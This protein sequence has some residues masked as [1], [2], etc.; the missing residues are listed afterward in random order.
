MYKKLHSVLR[1]N[2]TFHIIILYIFFVFLILYLNKNLYFSFENIKHFSTYFRDDIVFVYNSLLYSQGLEI[3]HLDHPS[4]FTYFIFT[5][6]YK[7][8]SLLGFLDVNDLNGLINSESFENSLNRLFYISRLAIQIFS[9]IVIFLFYKIANKF[10]SN[11]IISF[12]G[13]LL[14]IF[15]VGFASGSNRIE[16]GLISVFF[17]LLTM[18]YLIKFYENTNKKGLIYFLLSCLFLF[19]SMMQKKII[20]FLYPFIFLSPIF[21]IKYSSLEYMKYKFFSTTKV[22]II[23]LIGLYAI[24]FSYISYKTI[25]NNTFFLPRDLDF[26]FLTTSYFGLN[27]I[28]FLYIKIFQNKNYSNLLTYNIVFG[29]SYIIYKFFLIYFFSA[30]V[31]VWSVS[32]TNFMGQ[33]NMFTIDEIKGAHEFDNLSLYVNKLW[34][35]LVFVL[36][37]YLFT[38]NYQSILLWANL[39]MFFYNYRKYNLKIKIS[40]VSLI[41]GFITIQSILLF[42]Y[43]QDTYYLNSELLLLFALIINLNYLKNKKILTVFISIIFLLAYLPTFQNL[44]EI[45]KQNFISYCN[46]F[47]KGFYKFYTNKIPLIKIQNSCNIK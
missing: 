26:I 17:A 4:L 37:K 18:F 39:I 1:N 33:L 13:T 44:F 14:F 47:D 35:N 34:L 32:F 12:L 40:I 25:I 41:I 3:H 24:V 36:N 38:Y 6:F 23:L 42:R 5:L 8:F 19:S 11:K 9:L 31:A 22:Y 27:I 46:N 15:S 10:S 28:L 16:S 43:E 29:L 20:F 2:Q 21:L 45:K 30:P 7:L